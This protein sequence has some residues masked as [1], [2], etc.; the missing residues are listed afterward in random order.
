MSKVAEIMGAILAWYAPPN[1]TEAA[2]ILLRLRYP[3]DIIAT[4]LTASVEYAR[5][6]LTP[7][8]PTY[9]SSRNGS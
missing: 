5:T 3:P 7:V 6:L 1:E 8:V 4:H 2:L 9:K